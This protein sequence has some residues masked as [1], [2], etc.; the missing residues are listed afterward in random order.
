MTSANQGARR[1]LCLGF[2]ILWLVDGALQFLPRQGADTLAMLAMG[3]WGQ[4]LWLLNRI[5]AIINFIYLRGLSVPFSLTLGV[6]QAAVGVLVLLGPDRRLGRAGLYASIPAALGIWAIGE[7][8]G[9]IAG[10]WS[11][12]I[13][14]VNG[15]PG[16]V[17]LYLLG[18]W[19]VLPGGRVFG[20]DVLARLRRVTGGLWV[21][22]AALQSVPALWT[23][24]LSLNF[25][26][27]Q[28]LTRQGP[29]THPIAWVV[30]STAVASV[31]WNALFVAVMLVIGLGIL[32]GRDGPLLYALTGLWVLFVW[33]IGENFGAILGLVATDPNSG[34]AW[35]VL[36][37]PLFL[38]S[39][40]RARAGEPARPG[41]APTAA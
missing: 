20:P 41:A 19:I 30:H 6:V 39:L 18:A 33:W 31:E 3:G 4:P 22:G 35:A 28:V 32:L 27:V 14:F 13:T 40:R 1:L 21:L 2:G 5:D 24:T 9:G 8:L 29:W 25:Y 38:A 11:G 37:V 16:A 15:G 10:L 26:R 34:P 12:G 23:A 36:L 7:W 17:M